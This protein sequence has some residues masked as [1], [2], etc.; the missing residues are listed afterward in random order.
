MMRRPLIVGNWKMHCTGVE[1]ERLARELREGLSG[2][3]GADVGICPPFPYLSLVHQAITGSVI[4]LGAQDGHWESHGAYTGWVSMPMLVD[5]GCRYVIIGHSERR[6][7]AQESDVEIGKKAKAGL[8]QGLCV[9]LCVGETGPERDNGVTEAVVERQLSGALSGLSPDESDKFVIAYEPV[10]AIGTG[11][12]ATP[13][14]AQ[15]AHQFIRGWVRT[16]LGQAPADRIPILYGGSVKPDNMRTLAEM[17]DIDGAL[18]GGASLKAEG[19]LEIIRQAVA[20][21]G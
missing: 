18:V 14:L 11:K 1:A 3:P 17:P 20:G 12:T 2:D 21:K 9:I 5:V 4:G 7:F 16:R 8:T 13:D 6:Q 10:W 19:F 15:Q